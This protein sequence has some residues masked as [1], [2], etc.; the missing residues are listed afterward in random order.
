M[1]TF[2]LGPSGSG[3]TSWLIERANED[4]KQGNGNIAFVDS[5]NSHIFSLDHG[6]R[7]IDA[8]EFEIQNVDQFYGFLAG[9]AARD[10][11]LEKVYID[12][13][14][15]IVEL[16]ESLADLVAKLK[17][18]CE[19]SKLQIFMGLDLTEDELPEGLDVEVTTLSQ[20]A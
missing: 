2:V 10:Y 5:D 12:G 3:K 8:H 1:L 17:S 15:E 14:Y 19:K 20:E 4:K 9:I 6:V 16:K 13:I 7:L 11:D 18:L